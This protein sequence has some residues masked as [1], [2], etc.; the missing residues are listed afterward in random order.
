MKKFT[1]PAGT[2][3]RHQWHKGAV[4]AIES[5]TRTFNMML[6]KY[7]VIGGN[8]TE[9]LVSV[10]GLSALKNPAAVD[11]FNELGD[12]FEWSI[13]RDNADDI[14]AAFKAALPTAMDGIPTEDNRRTPEAESERIDASIAAE[15]K[16]K[17]Q[18]AEKSVNVEEIAA[19]LRA[20]YPWAI[21]QDQFKTG[22]ARAAANLKKELTAAFPG[23][24]FSV[25][26]DTFSMG[27]SVT[28]S[29]TDGPAFETVTDIT[30]KYQNGHFNG[31]EDIY[32]YDRSAFGAAVDSVLGR[33]KYVHADREYS[34]DIKEQAQRAICTA[35][36]VEFD[37]P[38]TICDP[39]AS[40]YH[41]R[42]CRHKAW[43]ILH[44]QDIPR[45]A[46]IESTEDCD[47]F[48][49][50]QFVFSA[51]DP[52]PQSSGACSIEEHTHTKRNC[53]VFMVVMHERVDRDEFNRLRREAKSLGGWYSRK[54][55]STPAGF[56]F[57]EMATAER[58]AAENFG[59]GENPP[60]DK[61]RNARKEAGPCPAMA[62]K[63]RKMA[64]NL[65]PQIDNKLGDRLTNTPKRQ[66]EAASARIDGARLE[67]TQQA[68][69]ALASLYESGNV[70]AALAAVTTKKAIYELLGTVTESHGYYHIGDTGAPSK[71]TPEAVA[72]WSLVTGQT[73]EEK[74]ADELRE[75]IESL[76]FASIPGYFPTPPAVIEKML[77]FA[78][79]K[80]THSVLEPSA[81]SG[82]IVDALP[83]ECMTVVYERNHALCEIL[84]AK[85]FDARPLDFLESNGEFRFDRVLMNPPF[86]NLQDVD[87]VRH[88]FDKLK[89]GGRLV[90]IM[91]PGPFFRD[92]RK[93]TDFRQWFAAHG[94]ESH[95]LEPGSFKESGTGVAS[96]LVVIDRE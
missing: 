43:Q 83:D 53:Q 74:Q 3:N 62:E 66:R 63:L 68:L 69:N 77:D 82:A 71:T 90:S 55:R 75:K 22:S 73:D 54:W 33:A 6:Q 59:N 78:D 60:P 24:R 86:E 34:D 84:R 81:G 1:L 67:R 50:H 41:S 64:D 51:P 58:F 18:A 39:I 87:H 93:A 91:S 28:A 61:P 70:P 9:S 16:R 37:G 35:Y 8:E 47:G 96:K 40:D 36:G 32:E 20:R 29:Y 30:G 27:N 38:E 49:G 14:A 95:D 19:K 45:G 48:P 17:A 52:A 12:R 7:G 65:Q 79:V 85:G 46:S 25:T 26:S 56:A 57:T 80:P 92:T 76:Q 10:F 72:L 15:E 89:S 94:G 44:Q 4:K 88:A 31:M 5:V 42:N 2:T 11:L 21:S 13:T 23:V